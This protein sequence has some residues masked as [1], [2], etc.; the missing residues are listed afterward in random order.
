MIRPERLSLYE[1]Q[2]CS[3]PFVKNVATSPKLCNLSRTWPEQVSLPPMMISPMLPGGSYD[4]LCHDFF[5]SLSICSLLLSTR[6]HLFPLKETLALAPQ[7][8]AATFVVLLAV[9]R[10][11]LALAVVAPI[12]VLVSHYPNLVQQ[13]FVPSHF[14]DLF[15]EQHCFQRL[16]ALTDDAHR[17][18]T[19]RALVG[20]P[21]PQ[22]QQNIY[23][24]SA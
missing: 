10:F 22:Q 17:I 2:R 9:K 7:S 18:R 24:G 3:K 13:N 21:L 23:R 6:P 14:I 1:N 16:E 4:Q 19:N 5:P 20:T 12:S 15:P 11:S 8:H